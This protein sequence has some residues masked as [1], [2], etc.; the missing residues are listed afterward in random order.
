MA[1][2]YQ[3]IFNAFLKK[4]ERD[5][6][7]FSYLHVSQLDAEKIVEERCLAFLDEAC[8]RLMLEGSPSVNFFD[9]DDTNQAFNF[10]LTG[11]ELYLI[12]CLMY[13]AYL[14]RDIAYLKNITV[15]YSPA[16]LKVFDPS[17]WRSTF[18]AMYENVQAENLRLLDQYSN[19]D[20]RDCSYITVDFAA[21]NVDS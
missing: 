16:D 4:V 21:N 11:T 14:S 6:A 17:N 7:F 12:P 19:R 8:G 15:N 2:G 13:E 9:R 18:Q 20:R 5:R 10:D 1:T 3:G